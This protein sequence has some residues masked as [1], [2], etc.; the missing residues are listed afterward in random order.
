[1]YN[2][3]HVCRPGCLCKQPALAYSENTVPEVKFPGKAGIAPY[4][5]TNKRGIPVTQAR[6]IIFLNDKWPAFTI[7][8]ITLGKTPHIISG[9]GGLGGARVPIQTR[10][11]RQY[12]SLPS[13]GERGNGG[14]LFLPESGKNTI[15]LLTWN[16]DSLSLSRNRSNASHAETQFLNWIQ[17]HI[18][19]YPHFVN[20]IRAIHLFI[21]NSPCGACTGGICAF[22][23]KYNLGNK[24][25]VSWQKRYNKETSSTLNLQRL[26]RC[27]IS[28]SPAVQSEIQAEI[29]PQLKNIKVESQQKH[30]YI[31]D[32]RVH[33]NKSQAVNRREERL[34]SNTQKPASLLSRVFASPHN[35]ARVKRLFQ[36]II[37]QGLYRQRKGGGYEATLSFK[38]PTGWSYGQ[39]VNRLKVI[40]DQKGDWHYYPVP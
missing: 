4:V 26:Q 35:Y 24:L 21:N 38:Y 6:I 39:P 37:D 5:A 12:V 16:V 32:K 18:R 11:K 9:I 8:T 20:R 23:K 1:M 40:I 3:S 30:T 31:L 2:Q 29:K 7:Q 25:K 14:V 33:A 36:G 17:A 10:G 22:V 13:T 34:M 28:V 27:G 19:Q 15:H